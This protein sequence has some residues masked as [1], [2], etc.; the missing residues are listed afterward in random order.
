MTR[1]CLTLLLA[2]SLPLRAQSPLPILDVCT[3][4]KNL[5]FYAGKIVKIEADVH[6]D[7]DTWLGDDACDP[8]L[9]IRG[10]KFQALI[11]PFFT[12]SAEVRQAFGMMTD[13]KG[14]KQFTESIE[15]LEIEKQKLRI[16]VDGFLVTRR[17]GHTLVSERDPASRL[18][19][20]HLGM[21]PAQLVVR[22]VHS[23]SAID[24][25]N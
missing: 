3:V 18:G 22:Y 7:V 13:T 5:D 21:A 6:L 2:F 19:F 14:M 15:K 1:A 20:G 4:L 17:P 9:R 8:D 10:V 23:I 24:V 11:K 16:V 25:S 12:D